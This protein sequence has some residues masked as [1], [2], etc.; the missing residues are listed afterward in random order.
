MPFLK[1]LLAAAPAFWLFV[2]NASIDA[3]RLGFVL[4]PT[5]E[6]WSLRGV[7]GAYYFGQFAGGA[8]DELT[9]NGSIGIRTSGAQA[10]LLGP[11]GELLRTVQ[12]DGSKVQRAGLSTIDESAFVLTQTELWRIDRDRADRFTLDQLTGFDDAAKIVGISGAGPY[13]ELAT[14]AEGQ[15]SIR[16]IWLDGNNESILRETFSGSPQQYLFLSEGMSLWCEDSV[17][18]LRRAD[19][20]TVHVDTQASIARVDWIGRNL[21]HASAA[22]GDSDERHFAVH[23]GGDL[24]L[25]QD[26]F[27]KV[28]QLP[29]SPQ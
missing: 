21:F 13:V 12:L 4:L 8:T 16:R 18:F 17:L 19:G 3:P 29:E 20:S 7:T 1:P 14:A 22:A 26:V 11:N 2:A 27:L 25:P 9:F 28:N 23:L 6:V 5:R 10:D 15:I 24:S